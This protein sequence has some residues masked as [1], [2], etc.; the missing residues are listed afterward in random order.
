[1]GEVGS[2]WMKF[3]YWERAAE[4]FER[5]ILL[6][7]TAVASSINLALCEIQLEQY[8][9]AISVLRS[10]ITQNPNYAPAYVNLGFCYFQMKDY[11]A[12][13]KEFET[14]VKVIDTQ[15]VK[16]KLELADSYRMIAIATM[17]EKKTT[18]EESKKK[19]EDAIVDLKR[20]LKY[21]EDMAQ[22]HLL[23]G[24]SN[25]NL[26]KIDEAIKEYRR[27]LE[28]DPKNKEA[29]KYLDDLLKLKP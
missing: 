8:E 1:M 22:T 23:L 28:L 7:T 12:G 15:E 16:Y 17:M 25:Q 5:R 4:T 21:K 13:R 9:K 2:I 29:K 27:T 19:W 14:A 6:D 20:S 11:D 26:N 24:Q 18:V 3:R 10:A